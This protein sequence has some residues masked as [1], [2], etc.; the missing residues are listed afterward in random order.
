MAG[1]LTLV[2]TPIGNLSDLSPRAL[3]ALEQCDF[4][5]AE[6]TRVTLGLLTHFGIRKPLVSCHQHNE[7]DSGNRICERIEAGENG[8]L[9]SD[10]GMPAISDPGQL[11][12]EE[13]YRRGLTVSV[14]PGP[15]AAITALAVS[16][17]PCGRFTFEGFLNMTSRQRKEHLTSLQDETRT[18][19]FYEAPH[20]LLR[21]LE[22]LLAYL[23]DRRLTLARELTKLHEE[24]IRTTIAE[25]VERYRQMP[26]RGEFVLIV[27]GAAP[28]EKQEEDL[29]QAVEAAKTLVAQGLSTS[30]AAKRAAAQTGFSKKDIYREL[31]NDKEAAETSDEEL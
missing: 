29:P 26:P 25:A 14:V 10:A 31:I 4:I 18:M 15:C 21:T 7:R 28:K 3:A 8:V 20:K 6:D 11:L 30:E 9:V 13:C 19:I 12:V 16:G 17:L 5:A 24:V 27:E 1:S 23:G 2:G 22:D